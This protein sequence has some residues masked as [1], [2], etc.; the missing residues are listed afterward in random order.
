MMRFLK[1]IKSLFRWM[2]SGMTDGIIMLKV[3]GFLVV[4]GVIIYCSAILPLPK[5][6]V[7]LLSNF[8]TFVLVL[9]AAKTFKK[10]GAIFASEDIAAA[11]QQRI[12]ERENQSLKGDKLRLKSELEAMRQ[13]EERY[14][15]VKFD[16]ELILM[17]NTQVGYVVVEDKLSDLKN[18]SRFSE[19]IPKSGFI[20]S[21]LRD[22]A[23]RDG[24]KSIIHIEKA[25]H[26]SSIGLKFAD[27]RYACH[28][29]HIYLSGVDL[30]VLH[31]T[32]GDLRSYKSSSDVN[33][34]WVYCENKDET[35][36][37]YNSDDYRKLKST[38]VKYQQDLVWSAHHDKSVMLSE[39]YTKSLH[40]CLCDR[41]H[42]LHFISKQSPDYKRYDWR[43]L[44]DGNMG[45]ELTHIM[46]DIY[47][48]LAIMDK[49]N[50]EHKL[51]AQ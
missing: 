28:G 47:I 34:C 21:I 46:S 45:R 20:D 13:A 40:S 6:A 33:H 19:L 51:L 38:Y 1:A 14:T 25:Y 44:G 29:D 24:E 49:A 35:S 48:S 43:P 23:V 41:Y 11:E 5:F 10:F 50:K 18:D 17:H 27:I 9:M 7:V 30:E 31:D 42:N 37:V 16:A 39:Y 32:S 2:I 12:L 4:E 36:T 15:H 22:L 26:K 3:M 8:L